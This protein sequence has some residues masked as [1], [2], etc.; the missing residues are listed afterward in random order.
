MESVTFKAVMGRPIMVTTVVVYGVLALICAALIWE[1]SRRGIKG[2]ASFALLY[3]VALCVGLG[4]FFPFLKVGG[5]RLEP[6][7]L[8]ILLPFRE[9]RISLSSFEGAELAPDALAGSYRVWA[10][11]G[12]FSCLGKYKS[13]RLGTFDVYVSD[14]SKMTLIRMQ[15]AN[16]VVSPA[17]PSRF[18]D[19]IPEYASAKP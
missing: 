4:A 18:V 19:L 12:L 6:G 13:D 2:V 10:N 17:D 16:I 3:G 14:L 9:K 5:Y 15:D 1:L 8:T 11:G 7:T